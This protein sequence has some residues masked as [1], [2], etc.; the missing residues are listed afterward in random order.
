MLTCQMSP[1]GRL[2]RWLTLALSSKKFKSHPWSEKG[3]SMMR[4]MEMHKGT[5]PSNQGSDMVQ[6]A[7]RRLLVDQDNSVGLAAFLMLVNPDAYIPKVGKEFKFWTWPKTDYEM[8]HGGAF[9]EIAADYYV[10]SGGETK[11]G[12]SRTDP[13]NL[14]LITTVLASARE[15]V[16]ERVRILD[17]IM[18]LGYHKTTNFALRVFLPSLGANAQT[19]VMKSIEVIRRKRIQSPIEA[20]QGAVAA[21][22]MDG[23][24][25]VGGGGVEDIHGEPGNGK[26]ETGAATREGEEDV[27]KDRV[28]VGKGGGQGDEVVE[29]SVLQKE[30]IEYMFKIESWED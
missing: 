9:I 13:T 7:V 16:E 27:E 14:S 25:G 12:Y 2:Y 28:G 3:K 18:N 30:M 10:Y 23:G 1:Y 20:V 5:V 6:V 17:G 21:V 22:T 24:G 15:Q 26:Q 29:F 8:D 11:W 4:I 19:N